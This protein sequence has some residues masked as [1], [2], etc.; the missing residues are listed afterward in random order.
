M[1]RTRNRESLRTAADIVADVEARIGNAEL[2]PGDRLPPVRSLAA[3]LDV[4]ANTVA[5]AYRML[6]DR[7]LAVG[8]GRRGTF[9]AARP[10]V[11]PGPVASVPA[12]VIDLVS[13]NPDPA[14]LP[15]LRPALDAV[16]AN[17]VLYGRAAVD[18]ELAT[19]LA[20]ELESDG[21][22]PAHLC[23]V[24]GALDGI[25]RTL[26]A[27]C[28]PGDRIGVE[29]PG[30]ASI[31][32][33]ATAMSLRLEPV[34]VDRYGPEPESM[35]AAVERGITAMIIT[36]RAGNPS[37][38][39]LDPDRASQ[40]QAILA[41]APAVLVVEDDHAGRVA[42]QR[43]LSAIPPG[44]E[45][46]AMVRSMA[47]SLGPDLRLA[48]LVGDEATMARVEGRQALGVGWVSHL[49][50]SVV[51]HLLADPDLDRT[52]AHA[53][54]VYAERRSA[55]VGVLRSAGIEA[56]GRSGLNVWIPVSDEAAVVSE[57][58]QRG[59]AVQSGARFR[60]A[61]APG[62]RVSIGA[63]GTANLRLAAESLAAMLEPGRAARSV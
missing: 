55:V 50:Q 59:F 37:G 33:L 26:T 22:D 4:A 42:G 13:G 3:Q 21:V 28:R 46:W 44:A 56:H 43:Y 20:A 36:P 19:L 10:P 49:L 63:T 41:D 48:A 57:M 11:G 51:A 2:V 45:R 29:D 9:V 53:A 25:E 39:A 15:D 7:G 32:E 62:V 17:H 27:H 31:A 14:L 40:L 6:G 47:K 18:A 12:D 30:Y 54:A 38:S 23:I 5:A 58:L 34:A 61:S 52:L 16:P 24:G 35:S 8:E 60:L 1:S